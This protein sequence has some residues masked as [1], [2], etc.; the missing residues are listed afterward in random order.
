MHRHLKKTKQKEEG[1]KKHG[2]LPRISTTKKYVS[3]S[4]AWKTSS[5]ITNL[6][7]NDGSYTSRA[8]NNQ[9]ISEIQS[10]ES[11]IAMGFVLVE[12]NNV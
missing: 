7:I 4:K 10:V 5:L 2:H 11:A 9:N 6:H 8:F 12:S 1:W 3:S